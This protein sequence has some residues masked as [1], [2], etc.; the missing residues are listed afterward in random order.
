M[1]LFMFPY[2]FASTNMCVCARIG[3]TYIMSPSVV[4]IIFQ[5]TL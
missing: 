5:A 4:R 3:L 1:A 2:R